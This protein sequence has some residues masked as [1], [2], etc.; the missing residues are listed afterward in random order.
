M[1]YYFGVPLPYHEFEKH[2]QV[3]P[4]V[5]MQAIEAHY[6]KVCGLSLKEL[7]NL[8]ARASAMRKEGMDIVY[9]YICI[10]IW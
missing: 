7:N 6:A 10:Y 3:K 1:L 2:P 5:R 8:E 9:I 4:P